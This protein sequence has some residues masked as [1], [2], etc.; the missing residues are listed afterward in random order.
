MNEIPSIVS[1][2]LYSFLDAL[3]SRAWSR[4]ILIDIVL[5]ASY[6][7]SRMP[8]QLRRTLPQ[9]DRSRDALASHSEKLSEVI[10]K[11]PKPETLR[12]QKGSRES[13]AVMSCLPHRKH[14][15]SRSPQLHR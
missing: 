2:I 10:H 15:T 3:Q 11:G 4:P 13:L 7:K 5:S 9:T 8:Q 14:Q 6:S 12:P 1:V